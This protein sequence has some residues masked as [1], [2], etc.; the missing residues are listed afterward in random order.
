MKSANSAHTIKLLI[1]A[2]LA[3]LVLYLVGSTALVGLL[4]STPVAFKGVEVGETRGSAIAKI[5]DALMH[6]ECRQSDD[7]FDDVFF[8]NSTDPEKARAITIQS[9]IV[10]GEWRVVHILEVED[11]LVIPFYSQCL[12]IQW[13]EATATP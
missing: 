9:E 11:Y 13:P 8:Y 3:G 10:D 5:D 1:F 2:V 4:V 7:T 6:Y 12:G